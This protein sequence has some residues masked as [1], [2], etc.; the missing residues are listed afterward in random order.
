VQSPI[1]VGIGDLEFCFTQ[2]VC[3][4]RL[5]SLCWFLQ[6]KHPVV[7]P[8]CEDKATNEKSRAEREEAYNRAKEYLRKAANL[9]LN[10]EDVTVESL[11]QIMV[12]KG[13]DPAFH[14][15]FR[16]WPI[17]YKAV[18]QDAATST[19]YV[20]EI[21]DGMDTK[22]R[23]NA[24]AFIVRADG[25]TVTENSVYSAWKAM[26]E[27]QIAHGSPAQQEAARQWDPKSLV[28][29]FGLQN[30]EVR[31][32][33]EGLPGA[34]ECSK[35]QFMGTTKVVNSG[36]ANSAAAIGANPPEPKSKKMKSDKSSAEEDVKGAT[37]KKN[38]GPSAFYIFRAEIKDEVKAQI[39][40]TQDGT[41]VNKIISSRWAALPDEKKQFY[42]AKARG[43]MPMQDDSQC[44]E[45]P[46]ADAIPTEP[47]QEPEQEPEP[48]DNALYRSEGPYV[49]ERARRFIF[50]DREQP[51]DV[52]D[53]VIFGYLSIEDQGDDLYISEETNGPA[54]LWRIQFDDNAFGTEDLEEH[55]VKEA[56]ALLKEPLSE[57]LQQKH[58]KRLEKLSQRKSKIA[59]RQADR[60]RQRQEKEAERERL[61]LEKERSRAEKS[62]LSAVSDA[63]GACVLQSRPEPLDEGMKLLASGPHAGK[64][65]SKVPIPPGTCSPFPPQ[66]HAADFLALYAFLR[67]LSGPLGAVR[68][69]FDELRVCFEDG[70]ERGD[71]DM[72][73]EG[74][75]TSGKSPSP[76]AQKKASL[77]HSGL[78]SF[79]ELATWLTKLA[80]RAKYIRDEE[81]STE[82]EILG[83]KCHDPAQDIKL[84]PGP[85]LS[86]NMK[87]SE[88]INYSCWHLVNETSWPEIAKILVKT[89]PVSDK[90]ED[91]LQALDSLDPQSFSLST[92]FAV[93]SFLLDEVCACDKVRKILNCKLREADRIQDRKRIEDAALRKNKELLKPKQRSEVEAGSPEAGG[94][95]KLKP[96]AT[97]ELMKL[98]HDQDPH[99]FEFKYYGQVYKS[100]LDTSGLIPRLK[101]D[102]QVF[103]FFSLLCFN[104]HR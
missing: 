6:V 80:V 25:H 17:G 59:E 35:Y 23:K 71:V 12:E 97:L 83:I 64:Q 65:A 69:S 24:P 18:Y 2:L 51:I 102:D 60:D 62:K 103:I 87:D 74:D 79:C 47:E 37:V 14:S 88:T 21:L 54:A 1:C 42:Q 56:I 4:R 93:L 98:L 49:G 90:Y 104:F 66:E 38:R 68:M 96:F 52:A 31:K 61:R 16:L 45:S 3:D 92:K 72:K 48:S 89:C 43:Q 70:T 32:R 58:E 75:D 26:M 82:L 44:G 33:L 99:P 46:T 78:E 28:D 8:I 39:Q 67:D 27:W 55:E 95:S 91:L 57:K 13:A 85:L 86:P 40:S 41:E 5:L 84:S 73:S 9:P 34:K 30:K 36:R 15:A 11:G 53:G 10:L 76:P 100:V 29:R 20:C 94:A 101:S 19:R 7:E 50:N 77:A 63:G 81:E 22:L